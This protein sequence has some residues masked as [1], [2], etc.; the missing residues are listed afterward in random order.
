MFNFFEQPW[1]LLGAAV[2]VLLGVMTYRSVVPEKRRPW[3]WLLPVAVA[4]LAFGLD[5]IVATDPEKINAIIDAASE[6]VEAE[7]CAAV[8]TLI[9]EDYSD[10][11]HA[12]KAD[13]IEHCRRELAKPLIARNRIRAR[14]PPAITGLDAVVTIFTTTVFEEASYVARDYKAFVFFKVQV[15]FRKQPDESWLVNR[16]EL[17][18]IDKHPVRWRE[19]R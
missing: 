5:Y 2:M 10:S 15:H 6:A 14:T 3:Q 12:N 1:T 9:A 19:V 18:E 17:L 8:A 13:L 7:D 4:A 16:I 11:Y